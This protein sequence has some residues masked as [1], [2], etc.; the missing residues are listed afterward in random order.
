MCMTT[1]NTF[2]LAINYDCM[3]YIMAYTVIMSIMVF[4]TVFLNGLFY[5]IL[6]FLLTLKMAVAGP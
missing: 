3:E 5:I 4:Y 6:H 2:I 1:I